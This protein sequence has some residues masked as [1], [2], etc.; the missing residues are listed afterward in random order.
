MEEWVAGRAHRRYIRV[1]GRLLYWWLCC[2]YIAL[3][4]YYRCRSYQ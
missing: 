3:T 4:V 1:G 2:W